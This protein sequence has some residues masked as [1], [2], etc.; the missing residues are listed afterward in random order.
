MR[1]DAKQM[2]RFYRLVW[3]GY[4]RTIHGQDEAIG[5]YRWVQIGFNVGFGLGSSDGFNQANGGH[6]VQAFRSV[7]SMAHAKQAE[8]FDFS[9]DH[10]TS[11]N[12]LRMCDTLR[13]EVPPETRRKQKEKTLHKLSLSLSLSSLSLVAFFA[14]CWCWLGLGFGWVHSEGASGTWDLI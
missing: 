5:S 8:I 2:A 7:R 10:T 9:S 3:L 14:W 12:L 6:C 11:L 13:L 1:M 4:V